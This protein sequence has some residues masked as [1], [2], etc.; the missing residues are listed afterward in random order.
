[1]EQF[2]IIVGKSILATLD[3]K[4]LFSKDDATLSVEEW[5]SDLF[6]ARFLRQEI[7]SYINTAIIYLSDVHAANYKMITIPAAR[8]ILETSEQN[9]KELSNLFS[10]LQPRLTIQLEYGIRD[11]NV[12]SDL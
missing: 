7:H 6:Q 2:V 5:A 4:V 12:I 11:G 9:G 8:K 3:D 1:M 10:S